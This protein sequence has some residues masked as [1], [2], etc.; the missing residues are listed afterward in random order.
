MISRTKSQLLELLSSE[1]IPWAVWIGLGHALA[2]L[3]SKL[4][5]IVIGAPDIHL[6]AGTVVRG[7]RNITFGRGVYIHRNLWLEAVSEYRGQRFSPQ[8]T[9]ATTCVSQTAYISRQLNEL[10][11]RTTC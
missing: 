5:G 3:K 9:S 10:R 2:K 7:A 4:F 11:L 1:P 6:G 8:S